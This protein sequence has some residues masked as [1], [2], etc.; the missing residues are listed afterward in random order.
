[1]GW[2]WTSPFLLSISFISHWIRRCS[3][4]LAKL[5]F[6]YSVPDRN[7][8]LC[9]TR[10]SVLLA[11]QASLSLAKWSQ[12]SNHDTL[13]ARMALTRQD[14]AIVIQ[15]EHFGT[16]LATCTLTCVTEVFLIF[17]YAVCV[18]TFTRL[19]ACL[20]TTCTESPQGQKKASDAPGLEL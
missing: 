6:L 10:D 13:M 19:N 20:C 17:I 9:H 16:H 18:C 7:N 2:G 1:M 4:T 14:N 15:L 3:I 5:G 11:L 12:K 8:T